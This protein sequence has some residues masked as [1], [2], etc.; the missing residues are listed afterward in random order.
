[1]SADE[2]LNQDQ[3][4]HLYHYT[5]PAAAAAITESGKMKLGRA[6][7]EA[8]GAYFSTNPDSAYLKAF[9]KSIVH[10][11]VPRDLPGMYHDEDSSPNEKVEQHYV[12]PLRHINKGII[13]PGADQ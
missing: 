4:L 13:V 9:G 1:M 2:N 5:S 10:I 6:G 8:K 7:R 11:K 12:V 3:F